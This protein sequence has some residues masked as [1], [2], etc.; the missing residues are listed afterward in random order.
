MPI[1]A[2]GWEWGMGTTRFG[3]NG[4][5]EGSHRTLAWPRA[6]LSSPRTG[7]DRFHSQS[8]NSFFLLKEN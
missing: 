1:N 2:A 4:D 3:G 5:L 8:C 7:S 6:K